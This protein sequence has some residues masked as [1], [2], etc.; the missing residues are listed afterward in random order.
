MKDTRD[1]ESGRSM[2]TNEVDFREVQGIL[3][4]G[5]GRLREAVFLLLNIRDLDAA[6]QW[7]ASAPIS[8]AVACETAPLTALQVAFTSQG[9]LRL[10]ISEEVWGGFSIEFRAGMSAEPGRS[11]LLGDLGANAPEHWAWGGPGREPHMMIMLYAQPGHLNEWIKTTQGEQWE[12]AF[13]VLASLSTSDMGGKE[14]FGFSDGLSQPTVDWESAKHPSTIETEYSNVC[15]LGEFVLGYPNEYGRYTDRPILKENS[16]GSELLPPAVDATG[17]RDLGK[18]GSYLVVRTLE[19]DVPGFWR[20]AQESA[21]IDASARDAFASAMVGRTRDGMPLV[22][23]RPEPIPGVAADA[24]AQ[25]QFTFDE[26]PKG[27]RCPFGS[28]VRRA[29]PR[30]ADLPTPPAHGLEKAL[31]YVGLGKRT[32][33]SDAKASVRFHRI[34]RRGREFGTPI[35]VEDALKSRD[36]NSSRGLHFMCLV[37][38][39]SR[40]FEFLQGAW[41]MSSKFDAMTDESDPLLGNRESVAGAV[42]DIFCRPQDSGICRSVRGLPRFTTVRGGGY[43]FLPSLSAIRYLASQRVADS[44]SEPS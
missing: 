19:Q 35:S 30:N 6:R 24:S 28:H 9:L 33:Q 40:Q 8:D 44:T 4:F 25:N 18:D 38:N 16:P 36:D 23:T 2:T 15:C 17:M 26:D 22:G 12:N 7:L 1:A 39:I 29:N 13:E 21:G 42:T 31:Q 27:V 10:G 5:Y 41:M 14:P 11:R 20:F 34:L 37:A 32:L 3:R 43:F